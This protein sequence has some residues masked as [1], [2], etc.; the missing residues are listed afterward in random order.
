M[1]TPRS[2]FLKNFTKALLLLC[3]TLV[4]HL[5][6]PA[7]A[8]SGPNEKTVK[9]RFRIYGCDEPAS[10]LYYGMRGKDVSVTFSQDCRS[11]FYDYS[12]PAA[13]SFY[14]LQ[15]DDKGNIVREA[16]AQADL[17]NT[18]TW[19]LVLL[20]KNQEKPG[21]Y[22]TTVL[23]DDLV[24]FPPGTY[25]FSNFTSSVIE[26]LLGGAPL[27][28]AP[29]ENAIIPGNTQKGGTTLAASF[30]I[31]KDSGKVP[32]YTN[33]WA[34][35]PATRTRVFFVSSSDTPSGIAT[36]RL[37]ESTNFPPESSAKSKVS[38]RAQ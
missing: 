11:V 7:L 4:V 17:A 29:G 3:A 33:N 38:G 22:K 24:S 21:T 1:R 8:E 28:L 20:C 25:A 14:R 36:K 32:L 5:C 10:D 15:T 18:G 16:A 27:K 13:I 2:K 30:S 12:G 26:G 9:V 37:M 19:P 35:A 6:N 31:I 23:K 34:I